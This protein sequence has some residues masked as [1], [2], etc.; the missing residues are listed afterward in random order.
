MYEIW[1]IEDRYIFENNIFYEKTLLIAER[2]FL[3]T[4][5]L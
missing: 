4:T 1:N 5:R 3:R 2:F